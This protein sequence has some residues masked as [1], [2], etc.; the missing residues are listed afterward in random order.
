MH[1]S[2]YWII[3]KNVPN[4]HKE[5]WLYLKTILLN[6]GIENKIYIKTYINHTYDNRPADTYEF[7]LFVLC[8]LKE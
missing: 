6:N 4:V 3:G 7:S 8:M 5:I 2:I 1:I